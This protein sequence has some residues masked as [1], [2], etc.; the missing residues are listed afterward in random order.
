MPPCP[1]LNIVHG[2]NAVH[3]LLG[4]SHPLF[5]TIKTRCK[6]DSYVQTGVAGR[7]RSSTR[8]LIPRDAGIRIRAERFLALRAR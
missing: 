1:A 4:R 6:T 7:V 5:N 2:K 8:V 3:D